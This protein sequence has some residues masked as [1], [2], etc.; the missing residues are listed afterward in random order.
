VNRE[1]E[2]LMWFPDGDPLAC[3]ECHAAVP[4]IEWINTSVG[5]EDCGDHPA[6]ECPEC[7]EDFDH[8]WGA[9]RFDKETP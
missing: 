9:R 4:R 2:A 5:C 3:P 7:G 1:A 8:V 6:I